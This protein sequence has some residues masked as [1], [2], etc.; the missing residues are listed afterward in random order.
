VIYQPVVL[1]SRFPLQSQK[2]QAVRL[3]NNLQNRNPKAAESGTHV[4]ITGRR[5]IDPPSPSL[6]S[7]WRALPSDLW[8]FRG[9]GPS[10]PRRVMTPEIFAR[11]TRLSAFAMQGSGR[12]AA[13]ERHTGIQTLP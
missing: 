6:L 4:L 8:G 1:I 9:D 3:F 2:R 10:L 13:M 5:L 11:K 12:Q 7:R